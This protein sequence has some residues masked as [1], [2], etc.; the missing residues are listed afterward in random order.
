MRSPI[1]AADGAVVRASKQCELLIEGG[2]VLAS[3]H[4]KRHPFTRYKIIHVR[5]IATVVQHLQER[6]SKVRIELISIDGFSRGCSIKIE[7]EDTFVADVAGFNKSPS[8]GFTRFGFVVDQ[9]TNIAVIVHIDGIE[10]IWYSNGLVVQMKPIITGCKAL[11]ESFSLFEAI[12]W[13]RH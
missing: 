3:V 2:F 1:I 10:A 5:Y 11:E 7:D 6:I 9:D 13:L 4:S 12:G 8:D